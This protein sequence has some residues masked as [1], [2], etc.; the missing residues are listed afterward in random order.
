MIEG[1]KRFVE[2]K[3]QS[4]CSHYSDCNT[5]NKTGT[6]GN[7]NSINHFGFYLGFLKCFFYYLVNVF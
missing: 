7:G 6:S 1:N 5:A 2:G 4:F 3:R